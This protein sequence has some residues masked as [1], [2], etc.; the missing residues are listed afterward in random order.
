MRNL[1]AGMN[2]RHYLLMHWRPWTGRIR[3]SRKVHRLTAIGWLLHNV[4]VLSRHRACIFGNNP[5]LRSAGEFVR[6]IRG[7]RAGRELAVKWVAGRY[8]HGRRLGFWILFFAIPTNCFLPGM[9]SLESALP[10]LVRWILTVSFLDL[11]I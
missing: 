10:F 11:A 5:K 8:V 7:S 1:T 6:C 9:V 2:R 3:G 4:P